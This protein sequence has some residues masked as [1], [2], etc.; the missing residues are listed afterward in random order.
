[1]FAVQ[2]KAMD[3]DYSS[4]LPQVLRKLFPDA[5]TREHAARILNSYGRESFHLEVERVHLGILKLSG[6]DLSAI[7]S[8][9]RLACDDFRDLLIEAE[10]RLSFGKDRLRETNPQKYEALERKEREQYDA[11]MAKVLAT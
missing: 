8:W 6:A 10:Y 1:M 7:E 3:R 11:W 5:S 2:E 9:T 4:L